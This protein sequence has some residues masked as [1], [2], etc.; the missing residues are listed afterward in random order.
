MSYLDNCVRLYNFDTGQIDPVN[1]Y[2]TMTPEQGRPYIPKTQVMQMTYNDL[3]KQ[4]KLR[5]VDIV[6]SLALIQIAINLPA[7]E[8][9][10]GN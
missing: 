4:G 10:V 2:Q 6:V 9:K 5:V 8:E 3:V 1:Q 7:T